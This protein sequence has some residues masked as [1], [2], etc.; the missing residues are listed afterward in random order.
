MSLLVAGV[1]GDFTKSVVNDPPKYLWTRCIKFAG[2]G[3]T[4]TLY[5]RGIRVCTG[6]GIGAALSMCIQSPSWCVLIHLFGHSL[7][8]TG[9]LLDRFLIWIGLDQEETFGPTISGLIT[10]HM[11]PRSYILWD[12]KVKV[13]VLI[14]CH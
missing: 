5:N 12:S 10:Q 2:V 7:S 8:R 11:E 6:T 3:N 1:Q 4:S 13:V 14:R 9:S